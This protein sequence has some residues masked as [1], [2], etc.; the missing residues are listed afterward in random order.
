VRS[1]DE[2]MPDLYSTETIRELYPAVR[3]PHLRCLER[4]G[5]IRPAERSKRGPLYRFQDLAII[6]QANAELEQGAPLK[7][8]VRSLAA[9]VTGQLELDFQPATAESRPAKVVS[10]ERRSAPRPVR[11]SADPFVTSPPRNASLAHDNFLEGARLDQGSPDDQVGAMAAYRRALAYDPTFVPA[12]I[13][14]ANLHYSRD[15]LVEAQALYEQAISLEPTTFEGRFNLGNVHHDM[16]RYEEAALC[17]MGA[18]E[19]N[20]EYADAHF[21]LAVTLEKLGRSNEARPYWRAYL[22]LDPEGEWAELAR[23]FSD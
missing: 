7:A 6:R 15:A 18:L 21:Y 13:N 2:G 20:G 19:V 22:R 3:E 23:E 1:R 5:F 8:I 12:I 16:G 10:I 14:L 17:Y 4:W 11:P 9:A